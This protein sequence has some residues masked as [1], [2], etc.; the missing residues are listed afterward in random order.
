MTYR[1]LSVF[2]ETPS[3]QNNSL[4]QFS[5]ILPSVPASP[6]PSMASP[7]PV[8]A[9][10]PSVHSGTSPDEFPSFHVHSPNSEHATR[11]QE[12]VVSHRDVMLTGLPF[13]RIDYEDFEEPK[14]EAP[15][16]MTPGTPSTPVTPVTPM[17]PMTP[18]TPDSLSDLSRPGSS[19]F[20]YSTDL[21]SSLS[22]TPSGT[23]SWT[24]PGKSL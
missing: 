23:S 6:H 13:S 5:V 3:K 4:R 20:S 15:R 22:H 1:C 14:G 8:L 12:D 24:T 11:K 9:P 21:N 16:T 18:M 2:S 10:V 19:Q 7:D 17:T